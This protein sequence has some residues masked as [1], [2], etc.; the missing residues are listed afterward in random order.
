MAKKRKE[1]SRRQK[2]ASASQTGTPARSTKKGKKRTDS[3][4]GH[5]FLGL[6]ATH[7]Q[8]T[9][10]SGC[11]PLNTHTHTHTHLNT[12]ILREHT[13]PVNKSRGRGG[14][15]RRPACGQA[16]TQRER[17]HAHLLSHSLLLSLSPSPSLHLSIYHV[18][19][20]VF[21]PHPLPLPP[22][23]YLSQTCRQLHTRRH[24]KLLDQRGHDLLREGGQRVRGGKGRGGGKEGIWEGRRERARE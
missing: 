21:S 17:V 3:R 7:R 20:S 19:L 2:N 1:K 18:H 15:R 9:Y 22:S 24:G 4:V 10:T 23:L 11:Q 5:G 14:R 13:I 12:C 8:H 16:S 6:L